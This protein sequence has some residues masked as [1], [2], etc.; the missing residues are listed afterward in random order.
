[1]ERFPGDVLADLTNFLAQ[2]SAFQS[3]AHGGVE[4][5]R[6][7]WFHHIVKGTKAHG[8]N[9]RSQGRIIGDYSVAVQVDRLLGSREIVV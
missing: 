6:I 3:V 5:L 1:M 9:C 4:A 7:E 8:L 2:D